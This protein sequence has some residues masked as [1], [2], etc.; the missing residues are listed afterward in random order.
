MS[1][2]IIRW[3]ANISRFQQKPEKKGNESN[4]LTR[5]TKQRR[6]KMKRNIFL[7]WKEFS[8]MKRSSLREPYLISFNH[9]CWMKSLSYLAEIE[10]N[11]V[12]TKILIFM[13][14]WIRW[15]WIVNMYRHTW[16]IVFQVLPT[17]KQPLRALF[18]GLK[19]V[20][21]VAIC[22]Y[23]GNGSQHKPFGETLLRYAKLV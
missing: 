15:I 23:V 9:W 21:P 4:C 14:R 6:R 19:G 12:V 10:S 18:S 3:T 2:S 22:I 5:M 1:E 17:S 13:K 20:F 16:E 11:L 7:W 8:P